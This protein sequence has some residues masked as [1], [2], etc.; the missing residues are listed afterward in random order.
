MIAA[1]PPR[2]PG[3]SYESLVARV[4]RR[5]HPGLLRNPLTVRHGTR[6]NPVVTP[7]ELVDML[8]VPEWLPLSDI[9][10]EHTVFPL[11]RPFLD[12][13]VAKRQEDRLAHGMLGATT[14]A[15]TVTAHASR[16]C[17]TCR[18]DEVLNLP[19]IGQHWMHQLFW[20]SR[21]HKHRCP[22]R[23]FAPSLA[24]SRGTEGSPIVTDCT[25]AN[26]ARFLH[27]IE[28]ETI[29]LSTAKLP[30]LGRN[31]WR[32]LHRKLLTEHL[33]VPIN[34]SRRRLYD[35]ALRFPKPVRAWLRLNYTS[36]CD[37][38]LEATVTRPAGVTNPV[39]HL[40]LLHLCGITTKQAVQLMGKSVAHTQTHEQLMLPFAAPHER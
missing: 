31:R 26:A 22:L 9:I 37:N 5:M 30:P 35:I 19:E 29:W 23:T 13:D 21:C 36:H 11:L 8:V 12:P 38:W 6:V 34:M 18:K 10:E 15:V 14:A 25:T 7:R 2:V 24:G 16:F 40:C 33:G 1:L 4:A 39:N 3:E 20:M 27:A 17:L 28:Q 32:T